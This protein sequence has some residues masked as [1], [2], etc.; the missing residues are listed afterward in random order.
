M[1]FVV[2]S[3]PGSPLDLKTEPSASKSGCVPPFF[4]EASFRSARLYQIGHR[5]SPA[6][7][8]QVWASL[9]EVS[10]FFSKLAYRLD[11]EGLHRCDVVLLGEQSGASMRTGR[12]A[13]REALS[14]HYRIT[15]RAKLLTFLPYSSPW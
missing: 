12:S 2:L 1:T 4:R 14:L 10:E 15:L 11:E 3:L 8:G 9:L 6:C 5:T 13:P 7:P